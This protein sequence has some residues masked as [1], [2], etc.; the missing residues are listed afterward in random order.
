M[1]LDDKQAA[2]AAKQAEQMMPEA[3]ARAHREAWLVVIVALPIIATV[4]YLAGW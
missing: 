4:L 1:F 2:D 3:I